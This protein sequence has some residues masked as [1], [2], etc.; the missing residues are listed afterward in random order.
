MRELKL[1]E[2]TVRVRA[3]PLALLFYKQEFKSDL[4][5]DLMK[6]EHI[7]NDPSKFDALSILQII[8]AMAKAD[9]YG[10]N[11]F[12]SFVSWLGTIEGLDLSDPGFM[13]AAME[14]AVN[15]F[16]RSRGAEKR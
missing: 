7:Q 16:F 13:A 4:L 6:M 8:W 3:T 1:G 12:P 10:G 5:G 15:G 14:E 11:P 9:A 2:Q